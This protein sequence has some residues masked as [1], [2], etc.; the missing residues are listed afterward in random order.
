MQRGAFDHPRA[1]RTV[2]M[3]VIPCYNEGTRLRRDSFTRFLANSDVSLIF[4]NDG[5]KDNTLSVLETMVEGHSQVRIVNLEENG[6]KAEAVRRGIL[7]AIDAGADYVGYWDADLA[8]PLQTISEFV[9]VL[10]I[11]DDVDFI[12]GARVSLLGRHIERKA[13]R[14]YLGRAFATAASLTLA[15]PVYDTQCGAKMLRVFP[16]ARQLFERP[17]GSRWIF[18]VELIARYLMRV[19]DASGLYEYVLPEWRDVGESNVKST[20]FLRAI[21]EMSQIYR[22]YSLG[23]PLRPV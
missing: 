16:G 1:S 4:V 8:T 18:D 9:D 23:Q 21:G 6:G 20:D 12:L 14:H 17:F 5:S 13:S 19:K 15:L 10:D 7:V 22:E 2:T 3:V 11:H